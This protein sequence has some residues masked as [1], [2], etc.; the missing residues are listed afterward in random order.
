MS[1][2]RLLTITGEAGI[3]G[4]VLVDEVIGLTRWSVSSGDEEIES[5]VT[6]YMRGG[7]TMRCENMDYAEAMKVLGWS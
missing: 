4:H 3:G 2:V 6:L 5:G 1:K 7:A